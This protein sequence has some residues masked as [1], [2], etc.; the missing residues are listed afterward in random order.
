MPGTIRTKII[1]GFIGC[2]IF[3]G[4]LSV[5]FGWN[6]VVLKNKMTII[7]NFHG[8]LD[9]ILELRRYEKN[10]ILYGY[11]E[12]SIHELKNLPNENGKNHRRTV[13]PDCHCHRR[14]A[15]YVI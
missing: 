13:G 3:I 15:V 5:T 8:L 7:E 12:N 2:F 10:T 14:S 9:D 1:A 11:Q 4:L 6:I